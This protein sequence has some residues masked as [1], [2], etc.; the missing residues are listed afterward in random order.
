MSLISLSIFYLKGFIYREAKHPRFPRKL[1]MDMIE[2]C[3]VNWDLA[4]DFQAIIFL[5]FILLL[6]FMLFEELQKICEIGGKRSHSSDN[7]SSNDV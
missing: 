7:T 2:K 6:Y 1:L 4:L 5:F 3:V